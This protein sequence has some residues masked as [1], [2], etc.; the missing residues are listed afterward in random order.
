VRVQ[1]VESNNEGVRVLI[2]ESD[3]RKEYEERLRDRSMNRAERH[4]KKVAEAVEQGRLKSKEKTAVW[5][6][7]ALRRD[8]GYRYFSYKVP[9]DGRSSTSSINKGWKHR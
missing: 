7:R 8:K 3:E 9:S 2:V 6:D 5:A 1:E 4:L